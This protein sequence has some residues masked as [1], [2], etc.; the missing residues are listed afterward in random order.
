MGKKKIGFGTYE[1][2][3]YEPLEDDVEIEVHLEFPSLKITVG[4]EDLNDVLRGLGLD[5]DFHAK[6]AIAMLPAGNP[7]V[8]A[9]MRVDNIATLNTVAIDVDA[10]G[11]KIFNQCGPSL[12]AVINGI[13]VEI[14]IKIDFWYL[15]IVHVLLT[16]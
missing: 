7:D 13:N 11:T 6:H 5:S 9:E 2:D 10:K 12:A 14:K 15:F 16:Y 4:R 3:L 1:G 8:E